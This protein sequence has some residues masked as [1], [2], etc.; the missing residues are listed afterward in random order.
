MFKKKPFANN[1]YARIAFYAFVVI[2]LAIAWDKFLTNPSATS[3][4]SLHFALPTSFGPWSTL[5]S[6]FCLKP[7]SAPG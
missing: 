3:R 4:L 7:G 6:G 1:K 5:S 2:A